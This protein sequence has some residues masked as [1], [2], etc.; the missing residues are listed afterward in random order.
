MAVQPSLSGSGGCGPALAPS[1]AVVSNTAS[2]A[3]VDRVALPP[4]LSQQDRI[5]TLAEAQQ[6]FP[7]TVVPT[8]LPGGRQLQLVLRK[9]PPDVGVV[10]YFA[11]ATLAADDNLYRFLDEGG[12]L[13]VEYGSTDFNLSRELSI[14]GDLGVVV[15]IG[16]YPAL[17]THAYTAWPPVP[18][19]HLAWSDGQR[20]FEVQGGV[21]HPQDLVDMAR[22][23]YCGS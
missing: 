20:D 4:I 7:Q 11:S 8:Y 21:E 14:A 3:P 9:D 2:P 6:L 12:I 19:F 5:V 17:I 23:I 15:Q 18:P 16:P 22:S 13:V 10:L 1:F